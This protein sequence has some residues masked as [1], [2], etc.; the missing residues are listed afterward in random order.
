[1]S[2]Q[3]GE[4]ETYSHDADAQK[5]LR[6]L[7]KEIEIAMLT[8][9]DS[10][11]TL[12]SRPMSTNGAVEF[13]GD[14]WFFTYGSSHKVNEIDHEPRVNVAFADPRSQTY[15]SISGTAELV[16]DKAKI[17]ELFKPELKAWFPKGTDE[18]DIALLKV[19]A[20]KAEYWDA[21]SGFVAHAVGLIQSQ[22]TGKPPSDMG[23][24]AKIAL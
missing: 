3:S 11:G 6:E 16:R 8:T 13:D 17:K 9:V 7:A 4:T 19:S 1:M 14:I 18:P 22:L 21:P 5:K 20:H 24:H 12:R 15:I 10:D 2:N 23:D